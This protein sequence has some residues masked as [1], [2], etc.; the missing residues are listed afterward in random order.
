[1]LCTVSY[2]AFFQHVEEFL[3]RLRRSPLYIN[4]H[5]SIG[6]HWQNENLDLNIPKL[7]RIVAKLGMSLVGGKSQL[8]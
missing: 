3:L 4:R 7:R 6:E 2:L 5:Q 8:C 1:M